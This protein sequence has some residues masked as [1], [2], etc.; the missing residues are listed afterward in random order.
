ML[1]LLTFVTRHDG[2]V[3]ALDIPTNVP[4]DQLKDVMIRCYN[5]EVVADCDKARSIGLATKN[6]SY[7]NHASVVWRITSSNIHSIAKRRSTTPVGR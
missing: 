2:G 4:T 6:H 7:D 1:L 3:E 5:S